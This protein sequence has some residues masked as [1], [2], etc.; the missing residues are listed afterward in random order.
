MGGAGAVTGGVLACG[1]CAAPVMSPDV[2][3]GPGRLQSEMRTHNLEAAGSSAGS[4]GPFLAHRH[5]LLAMSPMYSETLSPPL[6]TTALRHQGPSNLAEPNSFPNGPFP[7]TV[8]LE[9]GLQPPRLGDSSVGGSVPGLSEA[10]E[11]A[12]GPRP[13]PW[14]RCSLCQ[15]VGKREGPA[16][17]SPCGGGSVP[18]PLRL[19]PR[20]VPHRL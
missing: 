9:S 6:K 17:L 7:S 5:P 14:P 8:T 4:G 12:C 18:L 16:P 2:S 19:M 15:W 20:W 13:D 10:K 3:A 1:G 11:L